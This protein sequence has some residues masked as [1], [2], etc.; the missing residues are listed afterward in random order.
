MPAEI[1]TSAAPI[2]PA[3]NH[4]ET[5]DM[6]GASSA[7]TTRPDTRPSAVPAR[8]YAAASAAM[9]RATSRAAKPVERST[10][11]SCSR[12][13]T[14]LESAAYESSAATPEPRSAIIATTIRSATSVW[15]SSELRSA[16]R[17]TVAAP[18]TARS[19]S[20]R[21]GSSA[22]PAAGTT[23][24]RSTMPS[25]PTSACSAYTSI[26]ATCPP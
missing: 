26:T 1:D 24:I 15:S 2:D 21:S 16:G 14:A 6:L 13:S 18:A 9:K 3:R 25:R 20:A 11:N 5:S 19:I 7:A 22:A 8:A 10:A 4:S 12:R 23:S 17:R